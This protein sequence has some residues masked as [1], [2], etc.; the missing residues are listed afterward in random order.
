MTEL[1]T[2][3]GTGDAGIEQKGRV[4][5][6]VTSHDELGD[7]GYST[8][9]W[10]SELAHPYLALVRAGYDVDVASPR[11]GPAPVDDW[12]DPNHDQAQDPEDFVS[13]GLLNNRI[14][15]GKLQNTESLAAVDPEPY[16]G[17]FFVGGY[18]AVYDFPDN[19]GVQRLVEAI[20]TRGGVVGAICHGTAALLDVQVDGGHLVAGRSVTGFS[21]AEDEAVEAAV[22]VDFLT[23]YVEDRLRDCGADYRCADPFDPFAAVSENGRLVTGQQQFSGD[24]F[25]EHFVAAHDTLSEE[26]RPAE[27]F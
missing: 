1:A 26:P 3:G 9:Y 7:T 4:L 19:P 13:T 5:A 8:G 16:D 24:V 14:T 23:D 11:G 6:V 18:G 2:I 12:S 25:G 20:W 27:T 22:G 15:R 17:V 21:K 10:A